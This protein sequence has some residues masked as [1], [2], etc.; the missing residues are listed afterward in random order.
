[1]QCSMTRRA[2][3]ILAG[4][5]LRLTP[6]NFWQSHKAMPPMTKRTAAPGNAAFMR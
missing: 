6:D 1:M 4:W 3:M 5:C 2:G